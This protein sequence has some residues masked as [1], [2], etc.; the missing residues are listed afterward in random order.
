MDKISRALPELLWMDRMEVKGQTITRED[1]GPSEVEINGN[2]Y[3]TVQQ[4]IVINGEAT[5]SVSRLQYCRESPPYFLKRTTDV[6]DTET[7]ARSSHSVVE[8]V[9]LE[10]PEKVL[11]E[12]KPSSRVRTVV[13]YANGERQ[14]TLEVHCQDVPGNVVSHTSKHLDEDGRVK[15]R[16]TLELVDYEIKPVA[17]KSRAPVRRLLP[18]RRRRE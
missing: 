1:L 7:M 3:P 10:M 15:Q 9:A 18:K 17:S 2:K 14:V 8:V 11:T 6:T 16:S 12:I 5:K 13:D 4:R